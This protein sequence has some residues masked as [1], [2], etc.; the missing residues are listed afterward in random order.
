M[1]RVVIVEDEEL[2]RKGLV[3]VT[4]WKEMDCMV[5]GEA[6]NG[7]EGINIIRRIKPDI[8]I[9]DV[10]MPRLD[11]ISMIRSLMEEDNDSNIYYILL[12]AYSDFEYARNALKLGISDYILKPFHDEELEAAITKIKLDIQKQLNRS[13]VSDIG[14]E[15]VRSKYVEHAVNYIKMNY[16]KD[17]NMSVVA[18]SVGISEGHLSRMFKKEMGDTFGTYLTNYRISIAANLLMDCSKKIYEVANEV[19]FNDIAHFS[20]VFKRVMG[21][22]PSEYQL[23]C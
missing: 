21:M 23:S 20:S 12:T 9:S 8:V 17:V 13:E 10:R 14:K 6:K 1:F 2:V 7:E 22:T 18:S 4:N 5:V 16:S 19:G 11:G 3:H 15:Q